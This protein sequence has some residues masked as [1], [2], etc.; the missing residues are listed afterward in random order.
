MSFL[1]IIWYIFIA[2]IPGIFWL[3]FYRKKDNQKDPEPLKLI[4]KVFFWGVA[5]TIPAIALEFA[6]DFFIPFSQSRNIFVLV[7]SSLFIIAPIEEFLKYI[8]VRE[9]VYHHSAFNEPI[10]GIIYCVT[11]ALGFAS[12]ENILVVF[13]EGGEKIILLRFA[14]A[15]LMHAI[16]SGIAGFYLGRAKFFS[17]KKEKTLITKGLIFAIILHGLYNIVVS[18][19]TPITFAVLVV[20]MVFMYFVLASKIREIKTMKVEQVVDKL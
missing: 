1:I 12:F 16:T 20:L 8:I 10:D 13:G 5:I 4:A 6:V 2:I 14:T 18:T 7:F 19:S 17:H 15:T 9:K 3:W 11:A